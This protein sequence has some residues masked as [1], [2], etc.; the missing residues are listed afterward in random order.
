VEETELGTLHGTEATGRRRSEPRKLARGDLVGRYVVVELLGAGGMGVV[1]SAYDPELDRRVALKLLHSRGDGKKAARGRSRLIREAQALAQLSHRNVVTVHDVGEHDG[2]V[3]VA[4]EYVDG[5]TLKT[6]IK[7]GPHSWRTVIDTMTEAGHGLAAA[8]AKD[9][10][11]RDF[12]PDNVMLDT[13]GSDRRV[14]VMDF[15]LAT[16]PSHSTDPD[17]ESSASLSSPGDLEALTRTGAIMGT[18]AYMAPEQHA[19]TPTRLSDQFSFCV[20]LYEALYGQ[21]PFSGT[22]LP[23]ILAAVAHGDV[24]PAPS[25]DAVPRW[26]REVVV[27]GLDV[28]PSARWPSMEA[29]LAALHDDPSRKRWL[30]GGVLGAATVLAGVYGAGVMQDRQ[31]TAD[32]TA[33]AEALDAVWSDSVREQ[34][35]TTFE[36]SPLSYAQDAWSR[37]DPR[38]QSVIDTWSDTRRDACLARPTIAPPLREVQDACFDSRARA[39]TTVVD[40]LS[41]ADSR[42]IQRATELVDISVNDCVDEGWLRTAP[43]VPKDPAARET[44]QRLRKDIEQAESLRTMGQL[45]ESETLLRGVLAVAR[46][47]GDQHILARAQQ[48]LARVLNMR[49]RYSDAAAV[50]EDAYFTAMGASDRGLAASSARFLALVH[51]HN[52]ADAEQGKRWVK[53]GMLLI[54]AENDAI[55]KAGFD[56]E[57][58]RLEFTAGRAD[59]AFE[60]ASGALEVFEARG[61]RHDP[62]SVDTRELMMSIYDRLGRNED[63]IAL[64][65]SILQ[66]RIDGFGATHPRTLS[67]RSNLGA[68]LLGAEQFEEAEQQLRTAIAATDERNA[69]TASAMDNLSIVLTMTERE[70]EALELNAGVLKLRRAL[71]PEKHLRIGHTLLNGSFLMYN[72]GQ[73]EALLPQIRE[74]AAIYVH[75]GGERSPY[76]LRAYRVE[77]SALASLDKPEDALALFEKA[78][79]LLHETPNVSPVELLEVGVALGVLH[80]QVGSAERALEVSRALD[81][82]ETPAESLPPHVLQGRHELRARALLSTGNP[83]A[84]IEAVDQAIDIAERTHCCDAHLPVLT[85]IRGRAQWASGTR[86]ASTRASM[87][88]ALTTLDANG[89]ASTLV[90]RRQTRAWLDETE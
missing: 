68:A 17:L 44:R 74:A 18:P 70:Q 67:A 24:E 80:A 61:G 58:A 73:F 27:R 37:I 38:V 32:C 28:D 48:R 42:V 82:D 84:A 65:R 85:L 60:L 50:A 62:E 3:F 16:A 87:R 36:G 47:Q 76:L 66:S 59:R 26:L 34:V 90:D 19:G 35:R 64:S 33:E 39:I 8:H 30:V 10:T 71:L 13:R 77:G 21:R 54:D 86:H 12:K 88:A 40:M 23:E 9:M 2:R 56:L 63:A 72:M 31:R 49:T 15:G 57:L 43:A 7:Q 81:E 89:K 29:L 69:D 52:L 25:G 78:Y 1:Y 22:T 11:H 45:D 14:V 79:T 46:A 83:A 55:A 51:G 4:M 5:L 20:T 6:W 75:N 41:T 53:H